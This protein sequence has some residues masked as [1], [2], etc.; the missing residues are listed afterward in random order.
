MQLDLMMQVLIGLQDALP[1]MSNGSVDGNRDE[2]KTIK[3]SGKRSNKTMEAAIWNADWTKR[4]GRPTN[5]KK[6]K[7]SSWGVPLGDDQ[8][9]KSRCSAGR[10][11]SDDETGTV[12]S[13]EDQD[14]THLE[15]QAQQD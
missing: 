5:T 1:G 12:N 7:T 3:T 4:R 14:K 9:M 2:A 15:M 11:H 10:H 6:D 13:T 8:R